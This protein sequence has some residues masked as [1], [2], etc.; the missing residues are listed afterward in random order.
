MKKLVYLLLVINIGLLSYFNLDLILPNTNPI[1]RTE[2]NPEKI[3]IL[4][5][6]QIE[7]LPSQ[8]SALPTPAVPPTPNANEQSTSPL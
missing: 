1:I 8:Q 4:N 5:P 7:A 6:Q 2:I 3:K